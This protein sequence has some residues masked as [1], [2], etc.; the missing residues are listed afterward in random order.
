[1]GQA[2]RQACRVINHRSIDSLIGQNVFD[3]ICYFQKGVT[4]F[5]KFDIHGAIGGMYIFLFS[6]ETAPLPA[7]LLFICYRWN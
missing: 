1:M 5:D 7:S 4:D 3:T 6:K 2:D